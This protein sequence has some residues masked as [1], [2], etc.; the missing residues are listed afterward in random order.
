MSRETLHV[1]IPVKPLY[2]RVQ[3]YECAP[4]GLKDIDRERESMDGYTFQNQIYTI[5]L[6]NL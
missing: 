1:E 3:I 4:M 6:Q 5:S 2:A